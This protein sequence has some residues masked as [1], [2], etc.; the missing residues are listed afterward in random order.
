MEGEGQ[1]AIEEPEGRLAVAFELTLSLVSRPRE[2]V[3][4]DVGKERDSGLVVLRQFDLNRCRAVMSLEIT[5]KFGSLELRRIAL[6]LQ[7]G[8]SGFD[9]PRGY[10]TLDH[11]A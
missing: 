6:E 10:P 8:Q 5:G 1:T 11:A 3:I 7:A 4:L 2:V 9:C